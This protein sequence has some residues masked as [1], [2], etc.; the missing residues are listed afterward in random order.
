[1]PKVKLNKV[2]YSKG[3]YPEVLSK[4]TKGITDQIYSARVGELS[5]L[6]QF[7][8]NKTILPPGSATALIHWHEQED[9]FVIIVSGTATLI[10]LSL[11]HI[12]EPTRPY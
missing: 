6:T 8:V 9:E 4:Y 5:G 11:I 3:R 7:G 10:D 1:M 12:S 2:D